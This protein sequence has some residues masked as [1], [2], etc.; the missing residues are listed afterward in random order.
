MTYNVSVDGLERFQRM[1]SKFPE[2]FYKHFKAGMHR[3]V[4]AIH[5]DVVPN[6]PV[7][8][9]SRLRNSMVSEVTQTMGSVVGRVG[10]S[11]TAEIYPMVMEKGRRPGARMPPPQA[12]ERWVHIQLG[13]PNE[14]ALS[15][16]FVIARSIARRG[17]KG[18]FMLKN[19]W[20]SNRL[21][22]REYLKNS[23]I[24]ATKEMSHW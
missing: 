20:E 13:V 6:T 4:T 5:K 7:G 8:V 18:H 19:A 23:L 14:R 9:S 2:V 11:L 12:L 15:V 24:D 10:S 21:K 3:S 16:A 22:V 17:I 1:M